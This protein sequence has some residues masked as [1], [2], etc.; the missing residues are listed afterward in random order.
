MIKLPDNFRKVIHTP[1]YVEVKLNKYWTDNT[2]EN[3]PAITA[4]LIGMKVEYQYAMDNLPNTKWYYGTG[5]LDEKSKFRSHTRLDIGYGLPLKNFNTK[6]LGFELF[7]EKAYRLKLARKMGKQ[8]VKDH[9]FGTTEVGVQTFKTYKQSGWDIDFMTN[10]YIPQTLYQ[11]L[12]SRLH[13]SEHQK[14]DMYDTN[15]VA[16]GL[17]TMNEKISLL[18]YK[19]ANV[20]LPLFVHR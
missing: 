8:V 19:E 13:K 3:I 11:H 14:E 18:H 17:H 4:R 5:N 7:S 2:S 16:R 6:N 15:G 10:E 1:D 20:Q 12:I 9:I